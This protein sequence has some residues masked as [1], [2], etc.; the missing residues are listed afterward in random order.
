MI[1]SAINAMKAYFDAL[2]IIKKL[3]LW[4]YFLIPIAISIVTALII[5]TFSYYL[6]DN[7]GYYFAKLWPWEFGKTVFSKIGNFLSG[8]VMAAIGLILYKHIVLALS[9]PFMSPVSLKIEE[10]FYGKKH[11]HKAS[12]FSESL[13]R[14]IRISV[15]NLGK[16]LL[17]TIPILILGFIPVIGLFSSILL[18]LVQAYYAGFG[19]MDYTLERHYNYKNTVSFVKKHKGTAI[20]NGI[21]FILFL[22]IPFVGVV[23][24]LP[25]SVTAATTETMKKIQ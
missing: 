12:T 22:L 23:L 24:V 21:I 14:G 10:Y 6:S 11:Q 15:R 1:Q 9:S 25:F 17:I 7:L 18:F 19:N 4:K 13:A 5:V 8:I 20:G 16:E 3:N 2:A